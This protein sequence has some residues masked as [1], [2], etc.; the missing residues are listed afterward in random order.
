M[1]LIEDLSNPLSRLIVYLCLSLIGL[2]RELS[3]WSIQ[4][5]EKSNHFSLCLS[6]FVYVSLASSF[7]CS[8]FP[9]RIVSFSASISLSFS[10]FLSFTTNLFTCLHSLCASFILVLF[11][12]SKLIFFSSFLSL[13]SSPNFSTP[14][15]SLSVS[16]RLSPLSSLHFGPTATS[17]TSS[18]KHLVH[19]KEQLGLGKVHFVCIFFLQKETKQQVQTEVFFI[20][21]LTN[22]TSDHFLRNLKH[23]STAFHDSRQQGEA[24]IC[25]D[26]HNVLLSSTV[27]ISQN[28]LRLLKERQ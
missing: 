12:S 8:I 1:S 14:C 19:L 13:S 5:R 20:F 15:L 25:N 21:F 18:Q 26:F 4:R 17:H 7:C 10:L 22:M 27:I 11:L 6:F 28:L 23:C 16:F 24:M 2:K 3:P 9:P